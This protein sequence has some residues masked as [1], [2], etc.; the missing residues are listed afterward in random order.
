[1]S[2]ATY[3]DGVVGSGE[4]M[5]L[6]APLPKLEEGRLATRRESQSAPNADPTSPNSGPN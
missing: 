5:A 6:G 2:P 3:V 4:G 1:M